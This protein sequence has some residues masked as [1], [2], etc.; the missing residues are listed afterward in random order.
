MSITRSE[1]K[2]FSIGKYTVLAQPIPHSAHMLRYT[3]FFGKTRL[4]ALASMPSEADCRYLEKPPEVPPPGAGL[5]TVTEGVPTATMSLAGML[6][7]SW[8]ALT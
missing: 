6:A 3:V 4:G 2:R 5:T 8:F 7:V 1:M